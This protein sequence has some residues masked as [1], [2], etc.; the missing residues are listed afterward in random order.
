MVSMILLRSVS[1]DVSHLRIKLHPNLVF[2]ILQISRYNASD[3]S[4]SAF[5]VAVLFT[6]HS[7][8]HRKTSR[9]TGD[10]NSCMAK[11]SER[12]AIPCF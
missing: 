7:Q 2:I 8:I 12:R 6:I 9:R 3:V 1:R 10:G 11:S 5:V 4:V